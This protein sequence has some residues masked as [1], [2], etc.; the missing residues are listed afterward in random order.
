[1]DVFPGLPR[2]PGVKPKGLKA[3]GQGR[4]GPEAERRRLR[5]REATMGDIWEE[6]G[7]GGV[8]GVAG[9]AGSGRGGADRGLAEAGPYKRPKETSFGG[10]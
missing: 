8:G 1:V 5:G 3:T 6:R 4:P 2:L 9:G 10:P 7:C